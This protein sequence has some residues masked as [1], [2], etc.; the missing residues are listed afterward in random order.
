MPVNIGAIDRVAGLQLAGWRPAV[1]A[2]SG[3]GTVS[4][5][6]YREN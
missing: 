1:I 5:G 6:K 2:S 4:G 3:S